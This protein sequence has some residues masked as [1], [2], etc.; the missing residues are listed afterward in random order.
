MRDEH[1]NAVRMVG[2]MMD[3]SQ[4]SARKKVC[5]ASGCCQEPSSNALP[6]LHLREGMSTGGISRQNTGRG[7]MRGARRLR[8]RETGIHISPSRSHSV[9]TH[10]DQIVLQH[11]TPVIEHEQPISRWSDMGVQEQALVVC[12]QSLLCAMTTA[13]SSAYVGISRD[14]TARRRWSASAR[15][16][17]VVTRAAA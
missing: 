2:A 6:G 9:W 13:T 3:I 11:G 7:S 4:R 10:R 14:V 5:A 16:S 8:D 12:Q 15:W 1:G 17:I